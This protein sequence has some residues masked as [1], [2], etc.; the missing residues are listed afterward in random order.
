MTVYFSHATSFCGAVWDPVRHSLPGVETV[1]WD[2]VGHGSGPSVDVP[3]D[4]TTF[5]AHVLDVTEPG[6][7]GVGHSMGATALLMAQAAD[8]GRFSSLVLIEPIVFPP[9][10]ERSKSPMSDVALK[11]RRSFESRA[12][13]LE[14]F[15][16]KLAGWHPE[17][18]AGYVECGFK[19]NGPIELACA[20]EFEADVYRGSTA[21]DTWDRLEEIEVPVVLMYGA[22]SDT[23]DGD[24]ARQ[25]A[26]RFPRAGLELVPGAG[27]FLPMERPRLVAERVKRLV[28][29]ARG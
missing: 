13:A 17:A 24:M 23:I 14:N 19:G 16:S 27:H 22:E 21:H 15:G 26:A 1:A 5:G 7:I 12:E 4:W 18:L 9:P 28:D 6:G 10:Y 25:Q 20:P 11:R 8:P 3:V 2:Q 29:L